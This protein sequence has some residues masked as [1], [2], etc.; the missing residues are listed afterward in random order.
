M[1]TEQKP[2]INYQMS[3]MS[4]IA[5]C[6]VVLGH[7]QNNEYSLGTFYGWFPY[8]SFHL[9]VF[10]FVT[11]YF[12]KDIAKETAF[13]RSFG[14]FLLKKIKSILI[15]YYVINGLFLI[16]NEVLIGHGFTFAASFSIKNWLISPW[17]R[18]A[19][20]TYAIPTWYLAALFL[21][22][23]F[24]VLIRKIFCLIIR[25]DAVKEAIITLTILLGGSAGL[26]LYFCGYLSETAGV[27]V[28]SFVMLFFV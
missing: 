28:R 20:A 24:F 23:I 5:I 21:T 1:K 8:Y 12:F 9:P 17:V 13:F 22:E 2:A 7:I 16:L 3:I 26:Y 25:N 14:K 10:L 11:G 27:Y 4:A 18:F 15:P 6:F 19:T